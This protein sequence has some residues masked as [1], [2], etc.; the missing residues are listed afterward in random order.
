MYPFKMT[1]KR[2][3]SSYPS[4]SGAKKQRKAIG[5]ELKIKIIKEHEGF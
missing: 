4:R 3:I 5:I 1:G 2:N